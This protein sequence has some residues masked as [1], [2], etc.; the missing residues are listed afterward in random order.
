MK[1]TNR[2]CSHCR[3]KIT[4]EDAIIGGLRAFCS[5]S[6]LQEFMQSSKGKKARELSV[7]KELREVREKY[8]SK[9]EYIKEAQAAFNKYI[10]VRDQ[11]KPC[12]SCGNMPESY[13]GGGVDAGHW[14]SRG[15]APHLRYHVLNCWAQCKRCNRYLSGA[16]SEYRRELINRIGKERVEALEADQTERRFDIEYLKRVKDI[17]T[18]R[19]KIYNKIRKRFDIV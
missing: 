12:I 7:R 5:Y 6:H 16:S 4:T 9:G 18:R 8:K 1:S 19:A 17:F 2:R 3:K 15:S 10:R 13:Y 11:G 14:R